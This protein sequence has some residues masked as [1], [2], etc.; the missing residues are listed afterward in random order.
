MN[1]GQTK[2]A[3][4]LHIGTPAQTNMSF[5]L[6]DTPSQGMLMSLPISEID[7]FDKNP[8]RLHDVSSYEA[9]KESIRSSG[10]QQPVHVTQRPGESV[11]GIKPA[12]TPKFA[13]FSKINLTQGNFLCANWR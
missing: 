3:L 12:N 4:S 9:I 2:A 8:R 6:E 10:I 13:I 1:L 11:F 7:F 5:G